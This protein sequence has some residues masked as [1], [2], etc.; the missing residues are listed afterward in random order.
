MP[1]KKG[2]TMKEELNGNRSPTSD[3][4]IELIK[5]AIGARTIRQVEAESGISH[6]LLG[7]VLSGSQ[8]ASVDLLHKL[9]MEGAHPQNDITYM[10]LTRIP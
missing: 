5:R 9:T 7:K 4:L 2:D 10:M 8:K 1:Q 3:K 6:G